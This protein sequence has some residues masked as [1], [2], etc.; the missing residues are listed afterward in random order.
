M[1]TKNMKAWFLVGATSL[2][3]GGCDSQLAINPV[4]TIDAASSLETSQGVQVALTGA[5]DGTALGGVFGG[6]VMYDA[7]LLADDEEVVFAGSFQAL[8]EIVRKAMV[9][10]NSNAE[11]AWRDSYITINRANTVLSALTK[12]EMAERGR[13]EGEAL[14]IRG[15]V[16]FELVKK[17]GKF[18]GDG[19]NAT[20]PGAPIV[21][22]P[23][24]SISEQDNRVRASVAAVYTQAI[25]DLTK[26]ESLLPAG[27][28]GIRANKS[29]AAAM[30]SRIY[31]SQ[32]RFAEA[33]DAANRVITSANG[34]RLA[35]TF[36]DAFNEGSA[37]YGNEVV[38]RLA[39]LETDITGTNSGVNQMNRFYAPGGSG[40]R[41]DIRVQAKHLALYDTTD[42]RFR[43]FVTA[44]G[45]R[46]TR[47]YASTGN[48]TIDQYIDIPVIRIAEMILTRAECNA[49]LNSS[50]GA[51]PLEDVNRIRRRVG[52]SELASVDLNA[53]LR[54][55][56]L[57]LAFE[58]QRL[59]DLKRTR[60]AINAQFP[61]NSPRLIF[62][63][64]QREMDT[65][66]QL[67]QNAGY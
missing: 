16:Y 32:G 57:E 22:Q 38:Y 30:L 9:P 50:T 42:A 63:I 41:A 24:T 35:A 36:A 47:K 5:Y 6:Q 7:E 14:F 33:R 4:N 65:N 28:N 61:W 34:Y 52:L 43:F 3:M 27:T 11:V 46:F 60:T 10:V 48:A 58:G 20:N 44:A 66:K 31:L 39:I 26:A 29:M 59:W 23:T 19:D 64:P 67:V 21:L 13:V 37:G 55:R 18:W 40:G 49:R 8:D 56:R 25:E 62:P 1:N 15:S 2:I 17:F 45:Q 12:V 51:A 54:E 53:I